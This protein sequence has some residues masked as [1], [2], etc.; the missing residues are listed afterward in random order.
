LTPGLVGKNAR[1][2]GGVK[3]KIAPPNFLIDFLKSICIMQPKVIRRFALCS[4][5]G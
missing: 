2:T 3:A 1:L 5:T 4:L